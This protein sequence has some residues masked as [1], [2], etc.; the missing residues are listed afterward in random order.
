MSPSARPIRSRTDLE[1]NE[2][3]LGGEEVV[4]VR[5]PVR[6]GYFRYNPLQ[7]AM[8]RAL[9]GK[10][11][12]EAL[13]EELG[14]SFEVH[15]PLRSLE[16]FIEHARKELLL[17]ITAYEIPRGSVHARIARAL[18]RHGYGVGGDTSRP[19]LELMAHSDLTLLR[20]GLACLEAGD[21]SSAVEWLSSFREVH[22]DDAR[23]QE[24][25]RVI[26]QAYIRA[27][28]VRN[29]DYPTI[30]LIDPDRLLGF[31]ARTIGPFLFSW[32][33][34]LSMAAF[35]AWAVHTYVDL[36]FE[37]VS[38]GP[39]DIVLAIILSLGADFIHEMSHGLACK[40]YG[41]PVHEIGIFLQFHI[42]P[43][44][45]CDTSSSYLFEKKRHKLLVQMAGTVGSVMV[46]STLVALL[47]VVP[48][49][50]AIY[51]ALLLAFGINTGLAV[52]VNVI[53]F[54]KYDGYYALADAL[55]IPNLRERSFEYVGVHLRHRLLGMPAPTLAVQPRERRAF[56]LY[57]P[58]SAAFTVSWVVFIYTY[59]VFTPLIERLRGLGLVLGV[60]AVGVLTWR[61][62]GHRI[63]R[64]AVF[65]A[66]NWR[67]LSRSRL[68]AMGAG[69]VVLTGCTLVVPWPVMVDVPFV[70]APRQRIYLRAETDGL[71]AEM[72]VREGDRVEKGQLIARL[73]DERLDRDLEVNAAELEKARAELALLEAGARP[74]E[75]AVLARR[76]ERATAV[77]AWGQAEAMRSVVQAERGVLSAAGAEGSTSAAT[78]TGKEAKAARQELALLEAGAR[79]EAI[80]Q[81]RAALEALMARRDELESLR[82]R[83][84]LTS[85]I[86]GIVVTPRPEERLGAAVKKG[87]LVVEIH[88]LDQVIAELQLGATS[89][90]REVRPGDRVEL[91]ADG[92]PDRELHT[93]LKRLPLAAASSPAGGLTAFTEPFAFA[94]GRQGMRGHAR[95]HGERRMLGYNLAYLPL[96][97]LVGVDLWSLW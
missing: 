57:A 66:R 35:A 3:T 27:T 84:T 68:M 22:P 70:L 38:I 75:K 82:G 43:L 20:E 45:Y 96:R 93:Q 80:A 14:E 30:P 86:A 94:E 47:A 74:V 61:T 26:E 29:T 76:L 65:V 77:A 11:S 92:V 24:L 40:Y 25:L 59:L 49:S 91:R 55:E 33:G 97:R 2:V 28:A 36:S 73:R 32:A 90:L 95:I 46:S 50:V 83:L 18:R 58:L 16:R 1:Y 67:A 21:F 88:D 7:A 31:L 60:M 13:C 52:A 62:I 71:I 17:D 41:G 78:R 42:Q 37:D 56:L 79:P 15:I 19:P 23:C 9:D 51:P 87:D 89:P 63:W 44:P 85:P 12:L 4:L 81:A 34:V 69:A 72:A 5:D 53:P 54:V 39:W 10:K 8:L 48:K 64:A 6:G